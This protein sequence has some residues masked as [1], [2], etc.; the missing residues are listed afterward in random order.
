[1]R[2]GADHGTGLFVRCLLSLLPTEV[3]I[4]VGRVGLSGPHAEGKEAFTKSRCACDRC[5][6]AIGGTVIF[7][8][9]GLSCRPLP[10]NLVKV[11][12]PDTDESMLQTLERGDLRCQRLS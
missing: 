11:Q 8:L 5:A 3:A 9:V 7:W 4:D 1:M 2:S 6:I 12:R 10:D